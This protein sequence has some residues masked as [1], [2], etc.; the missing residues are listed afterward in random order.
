MSGHHPLSAT[1]ASLADAF[2]RAL[3][4][5]TVAPWFP[6]VVPEDL[7]HDGFHQDFDEAWRPAGPRP[8]SVVYQSRVVWTAATL[9]RRRPWIGP[10]ATVFRRWAARGLD[11]LVRRFSTGEPG[12]VCF[13]EDRPHESHL[14]AVSFALFAASAAVR[15]PAAPPA[16]SP[17]PPP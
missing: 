2:D 16:P 8:R 10:G 11:A 5:H 13:W 14:Y 15:L 7:P 17:R 1:A 6:R 4:R 12:G 3:E 9:A